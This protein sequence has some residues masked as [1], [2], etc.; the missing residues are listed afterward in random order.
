MDNAEK[1][2]VIDELLNS[3][4]TKLVVLGIDANPGVEYAISAC[5][6]FAT[7]ATILMEITKEDLIKELDDEWDYNLNKMGISQ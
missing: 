3:F 6:R 5:L 2:R 7:R 4:M 1:N